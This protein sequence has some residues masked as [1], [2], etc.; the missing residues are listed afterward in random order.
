MRNPMTVPH[1][2]RSP[3]PSTPGMM[4]G[5]MERAAML[6]RPAKPVAPVTSRLAGTAAPKMRG[7]R[8]S[9]G[10]NRV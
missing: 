7:P 5:L 8:N 9:M 4:G 1:A 6:P 2:L 10:R 3:R